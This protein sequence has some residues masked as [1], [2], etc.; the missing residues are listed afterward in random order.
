MM[1]KVI[2]DLR[3][4]DENLYERAVSMGFDNFIAPSEKQLDE[5]ESRTFYIP[6]GD[7]FIAVSGGRRWQV[8]R[9]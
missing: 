7:V 4:W 5:T 3:S 9:V 8:P 2:L 1:K 6:S